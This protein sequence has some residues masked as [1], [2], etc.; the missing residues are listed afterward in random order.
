MIGCMT[1][2]IRNDT[3]DTGSVSGLVDRFPVDAPTLMAVWAHPD[4]ES[5]L[6]GGLLAEVTRRGGK[7]VTVTATAGEHGTDDPITQPPTDLA[8]RRTAELSSALVVL[9]GEPAVHLGYEDGAC[10][11]VTA[12][13][14]AHLIGQILDRVDPD[15]V[16]TFGPD[17]VTGHP[18]HRAVGCWVRRA[19]AER[20]DRIPL[21]ATATANAWPADG[22]D[23]LRSI[24]AFW[25]G[26]PRAVDHGPI[27]RLDA[28]LLD[29]KL[30]AIACHASQMDRVHDALG[31]DRFRRVAGV[32]SYVAA[33]AS[34]RHHLSP[35]LERFVAA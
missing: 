4:D 18:D 16:L 15:I 29:R 10:D 3:T 14:A 1:S 26:F 12:R 35:E 17:G 13:L 23:R 33:N 28:E 7:V 27:V 31:P 30:A 22:V 2:I 20:G 11:Q 34:A 25:P 19:V 5:F 6:A 9:G 24:D 21:L 32:E 8:A